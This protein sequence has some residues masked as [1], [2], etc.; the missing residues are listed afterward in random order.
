[1]ARPGAPLQIVTHAQ[2]VC[3]LYKK[4]YRT[5][6]DMFF[7]RHLIRYEAVLLRARFEETRKEKDMRK[8]AAMLE[9]GELECQE[10]ANPDPFIFKDDEGG[11]IYSRENHY[12]DSLLDHWHPWEKAN[13]I[14]YF[15]KREEMKK[16]MAA[17]WK[18]SLS[19]KFSGS[20][21]SDAAWP[22]ISPQVASLK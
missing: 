11:I 21:P 10:K 17:Y 19:K 15:N 18:E 7:E 2:R 20:K 9:E 1:M 13:Y 22:I 12:R 14:D 6:S 3:R 8:L 4:A 16:D 5:T